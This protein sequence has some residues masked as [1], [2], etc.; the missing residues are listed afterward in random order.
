MC[1]QKTCLGCRHVDTSFPHQLHFCLSLS[2][3]SAGGCGQEVTQGTEALESSGI[4]WEQKCLPRAQ[5][6]LRTELMWNNSPLGS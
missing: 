6:S 1:E 4:K 2:F 5:G 3:L